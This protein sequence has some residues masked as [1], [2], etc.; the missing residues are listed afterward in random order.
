MVNFKQK[1]NRAKSYYKY[2]NNQK[3]EKK[4]PRSSKSISL[5]KN[6]NPGGEYC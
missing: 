4:I 3:K 6:Q 2:P 5:Y 1:H